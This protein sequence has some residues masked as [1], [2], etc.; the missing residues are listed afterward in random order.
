MKRHSKND[1]EKIVRDISI[2]VS[3]NNLKIAWIFYSESLK[4]HE[5]M[6]H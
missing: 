4:I 6:N 3:F 1:L 2:E 5:M